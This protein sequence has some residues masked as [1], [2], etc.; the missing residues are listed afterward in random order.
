MTESVGLDSQKKTVPA[1]CN[2]R[3]G[4]RIGDRYVIRNFIDGGGLGCVYLAED[5][6]V[7]NT[8]VVVKTLNTES[9]ADETA[10]KKFKQEAEGPSRVRHE[11]VVKVL[12]Q[13]E[14]PDG[15]LYLVMEYIEGKSLRELIS[16]GGMGFDLIADL[17][18]QITSAL[19]AA[20]KEGVYHR[21]L[22]PENI[23][24][25]KRPDG[26]CQMT[27]IDFGIAKILNSMVTRD[28]RTAK[29]WG[30]PSYMSPEQLR[31]EEVTAAS[32]VYALG[33]IAYEM[34]TGDQLTN[35]MRS[36]ELIQKMQRL[37][38]DVPASV[39]QVISK[40]LEDN[41]INRY[42]SANEFG[43]ALSRTLTE[44]RIKSASA[45]SVKWL[46]AS[47]VLAIIAIST[48]LFLVLFKSKSPAISDNLNANSTP[49]PGPN[50]SGE[51]V[52]LRYYLT[53]Q[54]MRDGQPY[55]SPF[56]SSGQ[57]IFENGYKFKVNLIS[58]RAGY[59]YLFNE[60][61][62]N[63]GRIYFNILYPNPKQN[64]GSAKIAANQRI[65]TL[66][67]TFGGQADTEKFWIIWT[68]E[69]LPT[70]EAA[71]EAAFSGS[72]KIRDEVEEQRLRAFL[73]E[74]SPTDTEV[75]KDI[76]GK[77]TIIKGK[78]DVVV[79]LLNLEHR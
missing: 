68:K 23:L 10:R 74:H 37:R 17:V 11:G 53:V 58:P 14:L 12:D 28:T 48:I 57:E 4:H 46:A 79:S 35:F 45:K 44:T 6:R 78:G 26:S 43:E 21:D 31:G 67:N 62:A 33:V 1:G 16:A 9:I 61:A 55:E 63:D 3:E 76:P 29:F 66:N 42:Q 20:H 52:S 38:P 8:L 65:E 72:G 30:T 2:L 39:P 69:S 49:M 36:D 15:N 7:Y 51:E 40:A 25:K 19:S 71:R 60:G 77:Q 34:I 13:G 50:S 32:D 56:Q 70:L 22:K 27:L 5:L 47:V 41:P 54:K 73:S 75:V 18:R 64:N 59:L 24:V